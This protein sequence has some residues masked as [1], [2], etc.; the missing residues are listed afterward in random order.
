MPI[1]RGALSFARFRLVGDVPKDTRR[2]LTKALAARAFEGIDPKGDEDRASGFVELE[3]NDRTDFAA[4]SVFEGLAALF[5][6]RVE[7]LRI[8]SQALRGQLSEWAQAF[9]QKNGRAPGRREKTEQKDVIRRALRSKTEPTVKV[10]DVSVDLA[11]KEL[12]VWATARSVVDEV[13]EALESTLEVRLVPC[14]PASL[15]DADVL[16]RLAPT[17]ELFGDELAKS[18]PAEV[19]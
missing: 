5:A 17:T 11:A 9:E 12:Q 14:V 13:T 8:P 7:R 6:W 4:G 2:W 3:Q 18:A 1:R 15:L 10:F 19:A 16:D